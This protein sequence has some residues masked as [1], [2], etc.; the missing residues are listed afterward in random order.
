MVDNYIMNPKVNSAGFLIVLEA[1]FFSGRL[2]LARLHSGAV[3]VDWHIDWLLC[4]RLCSHPCCGALCLQPRLLLELQ[5]RSVTF[6]LPKVL[7]SDTWRFLHV[8]WF[9]KY[10]FDRNSNLV[11]CRSSKLY[12]QRDVPSRRNPWLCKLWK[13]VR[14]RG[15]YWHSEY[16]CLPV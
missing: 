15:L 5:E 9:S 6:W 3:R 13:H 12:L 10:C 16:D 7:K 8:F 14:L 2:E 11:D 4:V 1:W